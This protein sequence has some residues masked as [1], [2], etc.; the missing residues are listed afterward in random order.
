M[1]RISIS[2]LSKF[3]GTT[4]AVEKFELEVEQGELVVFLGP[5]GCGKTTTLR[6]IAG[7]IEPSEGGIRLGQRDITRVPAFDRNIGVVFQNY[8]LFPHLTVFENVAFGLRRRKVASDVIERKVAEGLALVEMSHLAKRMPRE[9]SGGQ[10][11]R[12]A[13]ARAIVI[14]PDILLLDEPLSNL[15]AKLR[16][17]IR[18]EIRRLQKSLGITTVL[19]T[20]DQE[21]AMSI[22]DRMVVM[23]NGKIQQVGTPEEIYS[24]PANPFVADFIGQANFI[25][26]SVTADGFL[27]DAAHLLAVNSPPPGTDMVVIRPEQISISREKGT[28]ENTLE[29]TVENK[30]YFGSAVL[31]ECRVSPEMILSV[32][33]SST[34]EMSTLRQGDKAFV[35]LSRNSLL[36]MNSTAGALANAH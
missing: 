14:S 16:L 29:A 25:K 27:V 13:I 10:Q 28:A 5:S 18:Q 15:D 32:H 17:S 21:E 22:A 9:L 3:Y 12:V 30:T 4:A 33:V 19:V 31:L 20:H 36:P 7:F 34:G 2:G 35:T 8:A 26:G 23:S 1:S 24:K 11:Q 6:M